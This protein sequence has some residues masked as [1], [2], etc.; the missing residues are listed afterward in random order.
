MGGRQPEDNRPAGQYSE[1][2]YPCPDE[3]R[4]G[5]QQGH[6]KGRDIDVRDE[7]ETL[8]GETVV[9]TTPE[10]DG[11]LQSGQGSLG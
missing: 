1:H 6:V 11:S 4:T 9:H 2:G 7:T 5:M 10:E 8:D 3:D